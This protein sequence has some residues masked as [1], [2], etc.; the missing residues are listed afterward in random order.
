MVGQTRV[1]SQRPA[2]SVFHSGD[3]DRWTT[4][5]V[6]FDSDVRRADLQGLPV[7]VE[8]VEVEGRW[9]ARVNIHRL[10]SDEKPQI[11][12]VTCRKSRLSAPS[13][14][15]PSG[16]GGRWIFTDWI[17]GTSSCQILRR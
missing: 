8:A 7:L 4:G 2:G 16:R 1:R 9:D 5:A 15:L 3:I 13:T 17:K 12:R 11:D 6:A 14:W 10:F